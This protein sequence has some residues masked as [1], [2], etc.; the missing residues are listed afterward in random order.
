MKKIIITTLTMAAL[1]TACGHRASSDNKE[2]SDSVV[3]DST[4]V[5]EALKLK[6]QKINLE[7]DDSTASVNI[8]IDWPTEGPEVLVTSIR[9]YLCRGLDMKNV[10]ETSNGQTIVDKCVKTIYKDLHNQWFDLHKEG[11]SGITLSSYKKLFKLEETETYVTYMC[12]TEGYLGGAH[13]YATSAGCTFSKQ[14]GRAIGYE[15]QYDEQR[16][17]WKQLNQRLFKDPKGIHLRN[18]IKEGLR[19][20]FQDNQ[21][22]PI[23][24]ADLKDYLLY[25]A[26]VDNLPLPQFPPYFTAD[27]LAFVYQQYEIAPYAAGMPSF[28]IP[29]DDIRPLLTDEAA[30][31]M[32]QKR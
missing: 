9:Q 14:S 21:E 22:T 24:D 20:Y 32:P 3:V 18:L 4:S 31:L 10:K 16:D 25:D 17:V 11:L 19:S 8:T 30:C 6:T 26:S 28:T 29:Y 7:Q 23:S 5:T 27:G 15:S 1:F 12:N 13:G 2:D